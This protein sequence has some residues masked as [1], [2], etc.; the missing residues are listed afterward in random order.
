[1]EEEER[2]GEWEA[3]KE[4]NPMEW[5]ME[6]EERKEREK[7]VMGQ[8]REEEN[9]TRAAS[10]ATCL[11]IVPKEKVQHKMEDKR[12]KERARMIPG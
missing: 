11:G 1:M 4:V 5:I 8:E 12:A 3:R 2:E 7:E 9:V 10:R 6:V